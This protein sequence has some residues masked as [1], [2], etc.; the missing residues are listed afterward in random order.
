MAHVTL[1]AIL[2]IDVEAVNSVDELFVARGQLK[3]V[4][5]GYLEL[6]LSTPQYITDKL[7]ELDREI[8]HRVRADL[9]SRLTK[10][11]AR[12][13]SRRTLDEKRKDDEAEIAELEKQLG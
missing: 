6:K 11:K 13:S 4:N 10:A 2:K 3:L 5:D 7:V 8:K 9:Q 12:R 1:L